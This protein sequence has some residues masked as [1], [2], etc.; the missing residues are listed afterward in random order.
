MKN[1]NLHIYET[2]Q[3]QNSINS[4]RFTPRYIIVKP[5]IENLKAA[6]EKQFTIYSNLN[7]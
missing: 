7:S 5:E 3:T 1:V 2:Q 4:N 6:K